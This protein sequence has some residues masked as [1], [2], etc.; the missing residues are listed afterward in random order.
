MLADN[1]KLAGLAFSGGGIRSATFNLGVLQK[2][3]ELGALPRFDY[4]STVSGGGYIGSWYTSWLYRNTSVTKIMDRLN[5]KKSGDPLGEEVRPIRWLRM[6]SN[7][8]SPNKSIMSADSWTAGMTWLRN[9]LINQVI[10]LLILL[11]VL[12]A[13][14]I[15]HSFWKWLIHDY[16]DFNQLYVI[17]L[18]V[19]VISGTAYLAGSGM[20]TFY[21]ESSTGRKDWF[22]VGKSGNLS[23]YLTGWIFTSAFAISLL[24]IA[25]QGIHDFS[26]IFDSLWPGG[27]IAFIGML[28]VAW[29]G[30]YHRYNVSNPSSTAINY[31]LFGRIIISSALASIVGVLLIGLVWKLIAQL[32]RLNDLWPFILGIP[33]LIEA[34]CITIV[35]R[36]AVMGNY[37]PDERREWWGR[38]G[39]IVHRFI[40][41][42]IIATLAALWFPGKF[43]HISTLAN[44]DK[45]VAF[46][47][48]WAVLIGYGVR[49]A[50]T[51]KDP[52]DKPANNSKRQLKDVFVRI[53]PYFFMVG[54]LLIGSYVLGKFT[55]YMQQY[56]PNKE[57]TL[58]VCFICLA[59]A[60]ALLSLCA[61]VNE[62]SLHDFYKN[63]LVRAYLGATRKRADRE[64][65]ANTFTGFDKED[66]ILLSQIRSDSYSGPYP[67]I[68]TAVNTTSVSEL[69]RQD[70][71]AESFVFSPLYCGFDFNA[72]RSASLR[73]SSIFN[74]GYRPTNQFSR[75]FGPFLGTVMAISGAAVSPNRG[76]HSSS[77]T[78]FLL[79]L[80]NVRLGRWIGNPRKHS[81]Q[82]SEP[83]F[84]LV[85]LLKDLI[86]KSNIDDDYV[87]LSDGG[88]FDNMGLYELVRRRCHY[89]VL[90]DGEQDEDSICEGLANAIRRCRIDFGVE[91]VI[92]VDKVTPKGKENGLSPKHLVKGKL[93][94]PNNP[95]P[96]TI[97]YI[98]SSVTG[99]EATDVREYRLRN[100]KFPQESTGDQFFDEAQ[101]ESYRKLGYE[102]IKDSADLLP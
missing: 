94:Y 12:A 19:F 18:S 15:L 23:K 96:G 58:I 17:V 36:M 44:L 68:N 71:M 77:A 14:E 93:F 22:K 11:T 88:H 7:Y 74:F 29:I 55:F 79:T 98:K 28:A 20:R 102:S 40:F 37:F 50:F 97:I 57:C 56:F 70:R 95:V 35:F 60:T 2:L 39:G 33:L 47:G 43:I 65:S 86:G 24:C 83:P 46:T 91:I 73:K 61:G 72:T 13:M 54:F 78:S 63:R 69:D 51:S 87:Y 62:F 9:T 101:F 27:V 53:A 66:D 25:E 3:A 99:K 8:L 80:F 85:Y 81:W 84:G 76:Y 26:A 82:R 92:D 5:P 67:L 59:A 89:I 64:D 1:M 16:N 41:W 38:M 52:T 49:T 45:F 48:G 6:F 32:F 31:K 90:G 30:K 10:L 42:W 75:K 21:R 4:L 100:P 34:F